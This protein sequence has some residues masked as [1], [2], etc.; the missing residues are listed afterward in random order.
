MDSFEDALAFNPPATCVF[1]STASIE[2]VRLHDPKYLYTGS[3]FWKNWLEDDRK[4]QA[5]G[6]YAGSEI[7][8]GTFFSPSKQ[9]ALA[10]ASF[11]LAG[12]DIESIKATVTIQARYNNILN[13]TEVDA[14]NFVFQELLGFRYKRATVLLAVLASVRQQGSK[15]TDYIGG[16]AYHK[17]YSGIMFL[18]ARALEPMRRGFDVSSLNGSYWGAYWTAGADEFDYYKILV[19]RQQIG[20]RPTHYLNIVYF[21]GPHLISS[22]L[23][24]KIRLPS[25]EESAGENPYFEKPDLEIL[26]ESNET[27]AKRKRRSLERMNELHEAMV[28]LRKGIDAV[29][30]MWEQNKLLNQEL[31]EWLEQNLILTL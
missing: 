21:C 25:G 11:Y 8:S 29:L 15:I 26:R 22:I 19:M 17:G 18:S 27:I 10:E 14:I 7:S 30:D 3:D 24:F 1:N 12:K 9:A 20:E 6:R 5:R 16:W 23:K 2:F 13:L 4:W 31:G 28:T